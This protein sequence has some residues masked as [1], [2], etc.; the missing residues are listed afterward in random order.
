MEWI[1]LKKKHRTNQCVYLHSVVMC[2]K[3][4]YKTIVFNQNSIFEN[5]NTNQKYMCVFI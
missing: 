2:V 4:T 3:T 1:T 5:V